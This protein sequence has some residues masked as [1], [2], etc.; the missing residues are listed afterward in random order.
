MEVVSNIH[1]VEQSFLAYAVITSSIALCRYLRQVLQMHTRLHAIAN[2]N[3]SKA[4]IASFQR[5]NIHDIIIITPLHYY[6]I[7]PQAH[8]FYHVR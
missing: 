2:G 7:Q 4:A 3:F 6:H 5:I 1:L 8:V